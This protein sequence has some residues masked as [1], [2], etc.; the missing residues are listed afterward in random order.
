MRKICYVSGT[1]ADYGLMKSTLQSIMSAPALELS[2]C[3]TGMHLLE[4][5]GNTVETISGDGFQVDVEVPVML[6]GASGLEMAIAVGDQVSGFARAFDELKPHM[7]LLLGDRGEMLAAGIAALHLGIPIVHIHGGER[8]GT[9]DESVRH[10]ISKMAHYHFVSTE[11]SKRRLSKMGE[12]P[13]HI[14]VT[15][16]PG[17]DEV[18]S[19]IP[20]PKSELY[21]KYGLAP[22]ADLTLVLFHPVVQDASLA[23]EQVGIVL[24][25]TYRHSEQMLVLGS[26]SDAGGEAINQIVGDFC[27]VNAVKLVPNLVR[28]EFLSFLAYS[29]MLVGNSSAGIIEAA[30]FKLPVVNVGDRQNGRERNKNIIDV[31]VDSLAID[32]AIVR[33]KAL[34]GQLTSSN[35][36]GS[37]GAAS[38]IVRLLAELPIHRNL[39]NKINAY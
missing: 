5:Y 11:E 12:L 25:S 8:S 29:K 32:E 10:A 37:G 34:Q 4:A 7:V 31:P 24:N 13:S 23:G 15:G 22:S 9:I 38:K 19:F 2:L 18:Y 30:S 35:I 36:Y 20:T 39:L 21:L 33:A 14:V 3:V 27:R 17:L 26:N 28:Q 16:A 1:R 6:S